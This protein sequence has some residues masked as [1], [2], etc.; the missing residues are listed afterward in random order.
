MYIIKRKNK[1]LNIEKD[2]W[3]DKI[4]EA[5]KL[6]DYDMALYYDMKYKD[7]EIIRV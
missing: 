6:D 5:T 4:E 7:S 3:V 2:C 1:Y